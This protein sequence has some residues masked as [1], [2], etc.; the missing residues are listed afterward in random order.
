MEDY[1]RD[2]AKI[3]RQKLQLNQIFLTIISNLNRAHIGPTSI[4][5]EKRE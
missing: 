1:F 4:I 2:S 5:I 3:S